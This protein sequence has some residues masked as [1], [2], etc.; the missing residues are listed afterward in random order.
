MKWSNK[1]TI[2]FIKCYRSE[3]VI[4]NRKHPSHKNEDEINAAWGRLSKVLSRPVHEL[5][6]K[7]DSL[8]ETFRQQLN[9]KRECEKS[10]VN[11][12]TNWCGFKPMEEFLAGNTED[13]DDYEVIESE[14]GSVNNFQDNAATVSTGRSR[15]STERSQ[16]DLDEKTDRDVCAIYGELLTCKL[17][18][19]DEITRE[20]VMNEIDS[21]LFNVKMNQNQRLV[22]PFLFD[23]SSS[24]AK[25]AANNIR[26]FVNNHTREPTMT[27]HDFL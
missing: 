17:R 26:T 11:F 13:S 15:R 2:K 3:P 12:Q 8:M 18:S 5:K 14:L 19:F 27:F 4:W 7:E 6:N 10:G 25:A 9:K 16:M 23:S 24:S 20:M 21:L 1:S 22:K